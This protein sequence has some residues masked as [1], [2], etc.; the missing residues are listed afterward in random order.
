MGW[1]TLGGEALLVVLM[2]GFFVTV[3]LLL[4]DPLPGARMLALFTLGV[5]AVRVA[6]LTTPA[7]WC[8]LRGPRPRRPPLPTG[9]YGE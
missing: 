7:L 4:G 2:V 8:R 5:V 9:R 3:P 6:V 1:R